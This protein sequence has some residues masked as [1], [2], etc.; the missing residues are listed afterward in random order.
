MPGLRHYVK[1]LGEIAITKSVYSRPSR[2]SIQVAVSS[3]GARRMTCSRY[4]IPDKKCG[5]S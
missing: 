5:Q 1:E 3:C 4:S 2:R